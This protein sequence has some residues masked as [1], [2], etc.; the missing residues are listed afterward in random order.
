M[1]ALRTVETDSRHREPFPALDPG[2]CSDL[3][4]FTRVHFEFATWHPLHAFE[5][6]DVSIHRT[7]RF[8]ARCHVVARSGALGTIQAG[9]TGESDREAIRHCAALLEAEV[10]LRLAAR[11]PVESPPR[12]GRANAWPKGLSPAAVTAPTEVAPAQ[13]S[14]T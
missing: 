6:I 13:W 12:T 5:S 4:D 9:A 2:S 3:Q 10:N 1:V 11:A 7:G 8:S 14:T